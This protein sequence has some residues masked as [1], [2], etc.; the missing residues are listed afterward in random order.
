M[1]ILF[2]I[3]ILFISISC[4]PTQDFPTTI[5]LDNRFTDEQVEDIFSCLEQWK[6]ATGGI[7]DMIG[8]QNGTSV[9]PKNFSE[10]QDLD[11]HEMII[12]HSYDNVVMEYA[13]EK[14]VAPSNVAGFASIKGIAIVIDNITIGNNHDNHD[15]WRY[16]F[17]H[18]VLH[19]A[20]HFVGLLHLTN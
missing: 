16:A 6:Y 19:E 4:Q 7:A 2:P 10:F 8:I 13:E 15:K 9:R 17:R 12:V 5:L 20:G 1:R 14:E 3:A 18:V 11:N